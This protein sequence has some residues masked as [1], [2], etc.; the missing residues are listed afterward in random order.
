MLAYWKI[1]RSI[2]NKILSLEDVQKI[3]NAYREGGVTSSIM[4]M[5]KLHKLTIE[6]A[7]QREWGEGPKCQKTALCIFWMSPYLFKLCQSKIKYVNILKQF[8][9]VELLISNNNCLILQ[10]QYCQIISFLTVSISVFPHFF[11]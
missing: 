1:Y 3:C 4:P 11:V 9:I 8:Q 2:Y 6:K 10:K 5:L 7:L